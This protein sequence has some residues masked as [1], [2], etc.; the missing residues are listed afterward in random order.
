MSGA[1]TLFDHPVYFLAYEDGTDRLGRNIGK[2]LT[3]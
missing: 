1:Q 3:F 2:G